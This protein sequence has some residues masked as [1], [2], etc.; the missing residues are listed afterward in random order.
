MSVLYVLSASGHLNFSALDQ[1]PPLP[2]SASARRADDP[3]ARRGGDRWCPDP[4]GWDWSLH[5]ASLPSP[6]TGSWVERCR[7]RLGLQI[8][9]SAV[10]DGWSFRTF[11]TCPSFATN[12]LGKRYKSTICDSTV[13]TDYCDCWSTMDW[14]LSSLIYCG[15][16]RVTWHESIACICCV[17]I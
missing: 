11:Y 3:R 16:W 7:S 1:F 14:W 2:R 10:S 12:R 17:Y 15:C 4:A 13:Q 5:T 8:W 9:F 6:P